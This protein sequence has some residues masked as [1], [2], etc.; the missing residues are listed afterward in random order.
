MNRKIVFTLAAC[1]LAVNANALAQTPFSSGSTGAQGAF[2]PAG[3]ANLTYNTLT[4]DLKTAVVT[5]TTGGTVVG[6]AT[7]PGGASS[8]EAFPTGDLEPA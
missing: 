6:T 5:A 8:G 2:P 1:L 4:L 3:L 7:L